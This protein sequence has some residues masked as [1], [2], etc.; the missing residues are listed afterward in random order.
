MKA[1]K[2]RVENEQ[3][4]KAIQEALFGLGY[5]WNSYMNHMDQN[6]MNTSSEFLYCYE[7]GRITCGFE[8]DWFKSHTNE[9]H[10]LVN[11]ET[12]PVAHV[13]APPIGLRPRRVV[14]TFRMKEILEAMKRY[15]EA[16]KAIPKEWVEE[17]GELCE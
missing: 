4:S 17:L 15:S 2:F 1:M 14:A 16:E 12:V 6:V 11:G 7:D 8:V 3:H 5:H 9:E 13:K 10:Q